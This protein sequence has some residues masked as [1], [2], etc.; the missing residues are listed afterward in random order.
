M[1]ASKLKNSLSL[2]A[3]ECMAAL[4]FIQPLLDVLSFFMQ[5]L[6]ATSLTTALRTVLL[7]AV[8]LYG[9][10]VSDKKRLYAVLYGVVGGFWLLHALNCLRL[11]YQDPLGDAAEYLKLVQFPLWTAA[12]ITLFRRRYGLNLR[13]AGMLAGNFALILLIIALSYLTGHP[14]YTYDLPAS[15]FQKGLLGWFGVPNAQSAIVSMLAP[16]LM[17][18]AYR[19]ERLWV[20][21]AACGLG[22][23]LLYF[24]GTRLAYYSAV[25]AALGFGVLLVLAMLSGGPSKEKWLYCAPVLV[26]LVLVLAFREQSIMTQRQALT[27]DSY[28]VYQEQTDRIMGGDK[29]YVYDGG[30]IPP[31]VLKKI[32]RVYEEVYTQ[33]SASNA[34]LL[35]DLLE[36]FGLQAVME[37]Y[38]YATKASTLYNGRTKKLTVM[39]L[40]WREQ[41]WITRIFGFEYAKAT[42][43]GTN[44]DP[45]NDFPALPYFYGW[46]GTALY[47]A[48]TAYFLLAVLWGCLKNL[49]DLPAFLTVELGV[50]SMMYCLGLGSAQFS[51]QA[52]RKPSVTVYLSLAAAQMFCITHS[53]LGGKLFAKYDRRPAVTMKKL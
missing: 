31:D 6:G 21:S 26:M 2:R 10:T 22:L 18:W 4:L 29:D 53:D 35:G 50:Y 20:F 52:L 49:R 1:E 15:G 48:F 39:A 3:G 19:T 40:T 36:R 5:N 25:L 9:F 14:A 34:P 33:R 12:F 45:E 27:A 47:G 42:L 32:T 13:A 41:D 51:G 46:L 38:H 24:T 30:E 17:L 11:G 43:N 8:S 7:F 37:H 23:G 28:A 16:S 44:Y